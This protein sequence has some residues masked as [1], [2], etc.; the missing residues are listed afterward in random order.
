MQNSEPGFQGL[1]SGLLRQEFFEPLEAIAEEFHEALGDSLAKRLTQKRG[2]RWMRIIHPGRDPR[3]GNE[4]VGA[5]P[6][7]VVVQALDNI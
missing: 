3:V 2:L 4:G 7:S 6:P 5:A 1:V